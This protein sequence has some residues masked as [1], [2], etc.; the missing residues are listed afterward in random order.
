MKYIIITLLFILDLVVWGWHQAISMEE[1][2]MDK[3]MNMTTDNIQTAVFAGGCFWCTES[4]FEKVDG[5][6]EV[7]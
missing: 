3:T 6:T 4:D 7:I 5:V 1:P 2:K